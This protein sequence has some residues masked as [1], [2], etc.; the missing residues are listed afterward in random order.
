MSRTGNLPPKRPSGQ[1]IPPDTQEIL[2]KTIDFS[3]LSQPPVIKN[4]KGDGP[5]FRKKR[6]V[7]LF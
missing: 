2:Q 3:F 1:I 4:A 7:P 5:N 6:T